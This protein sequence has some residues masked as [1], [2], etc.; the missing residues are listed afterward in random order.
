MIK[1]IDIVIVNWNS[2]HFLSECISS[3]VEFG[4]DYINRIII[5]DNNSS[6]DSLEQLDSMDNVIIIENDKN[7]GFGK[8]CNIGASHAQSNNILFLNPDARIF[9]ETIENSLRYINL[10]MNKDVGIL[11]VKLYN[12]KNEVGR[13]CAR[14]PNVKRLFFRSTGLEKILPRYGLF[15]TDFDHLSTR[16]VDQVIGAFFLVKRDVFNKLN[17]FDERFFVYMEEVDFS[18]RAKLLGWKSIYYSEA[19]AFHYGGASSSKVNA[20]RLFYN[21]RSRLQ[22]S[23]KHFG[24][25]SLAIIFFLTLFVEPITRIVFF[26]INFKIYEV[27]STLKS[28]RKLIGWIFLGKDYVK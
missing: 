16:E 6:D 28:Y 18:F 26:L 8:S 14:F 24:N 17:G 7:L 25:F 3:L 2:G 5:V 12:Q 4:E 11:G 21:L 1:V 19:A 15:M 9:E 10:P 20:L 23:E 13:S 27:V 22:Y